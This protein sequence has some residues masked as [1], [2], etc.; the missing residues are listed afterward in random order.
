MSSTKIARFRVGDWISLLYGPRRILAQV[1]EDRGRIG[2]R[3]RR[4]YGVRI[5]FAEGT[6]TILEVGEDEVEATTEAERARWRATGSIA[7]HQTVTYF[8]NGEDGGGPEPRY[9]YLLIAR[10]AA[11]PDSGVVSII[12]MLP[13]QVVAAAKNPPPKIVAPSGGPEAALLKAEEYLDTLHPGLRKT[14]G[15]RRP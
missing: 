5:D 9:H 4:L 12:P 15:E 10:P 7:F 6:P 3:G 11:E 13:A 14:V 2:V 1:I 8:G